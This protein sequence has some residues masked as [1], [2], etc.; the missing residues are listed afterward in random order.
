[1]SNLNQVILQGNLVADP[2]L[3]GDENK[4]ARFT[5]AV[6]NGFGDY[7]DTT[8]VDC[9]AFK[10]QAIVIAKHLSKGKQVIVRGTL[11]QNKWEDKETGK[12]RSKL[13]VKLEN[14]SGFFF[15]GNA[16]VNGATEVEAE[17]EPEVVTEEL[18]EA[19]VAAG[20]TEG[21]P[22]PVAVAAGEAEAET[23]ATVD[24]KTLF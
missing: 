2:K 8:F 24:G 6:N 20:E 5:I 13:E 14:V 21:E 1:M 11:I 18:A 9:V 22:E 10:A 19:T 23:E 16:V 12:N 15:T 3:F 7:E 17:D 4:V